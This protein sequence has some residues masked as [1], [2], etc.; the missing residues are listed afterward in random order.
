MGMRPL[1]TDDTSTTVT[2][3]LPT[4]TAAAIAQ[5]AAARGVRRSDVMREAVDAWLREA[6]LPA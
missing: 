4:R 2:T 6:A 3:R 5:Q 1:S